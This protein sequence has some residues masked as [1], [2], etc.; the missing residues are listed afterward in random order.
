MFQIGIFLVFQLFLIIWVGS[1]IVVGIFFLVRAYQTKLKSLIYGGIALII[2][3]IS[4]IGRQLFDFNLLVTR[5][6]LSFGFILVVVFTNMIF[7]RDRKSKLPTFIL[8]ITV[9]NFFLETGLAF[10][11]MAIVS[12]YT[13]YLN[14]TQDT[15]N[16]FIVFNWMAWSTFSAYKEIRVLDIEPWVKTRYKI[17]S[18]ITFF[19]S[20]HNIPFFFQPW[21][22]DFGDPNDIR[23]FIVFGIISVFAII[24][25]IGFSL[26]WFIPK[27]FKR[28]LNKGYN[29]IEEKEYTEEELMALIRKQITEEDS[30]R[31]N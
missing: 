4:Q 3:A 21:N 30:N 13:F 17:L 2:A 22:V 29:I 5:M 12:D 8:I 6:I 20:F 24:F 19:F 9:I 28:F 16:R 18:F 10:F 1:F 11:S 15:L 27:W 14:V 26:T 31:N 25:A 7:H 23:S